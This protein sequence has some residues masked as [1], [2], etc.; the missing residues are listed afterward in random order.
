[1]N[2]FRNFS[3]VKIFT[4]DSLVDH[5]NKVQ[6]GEFKNSSNYQQNNITY[7]NTYGWTKEVC[8]EVR[9]SLRDKGKHVMNCNTFKA[10]RIS[11]NDS[12]YAQKLFP[13]VK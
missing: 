9:D 3:S 2:I 5:I 13:K 6:R 11:D 12:D 4:K 10:M 1:M 7:I 8:H